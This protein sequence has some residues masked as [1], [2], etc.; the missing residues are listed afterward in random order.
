MNSVDEQRIPVPDLGPPSWSRRY[1][2]NLERL[3]SG[4]RAEIAEVVRHLSGREQA[5]GISPGE[6]RMLAR[7]RQMLDDGSDGAAGVREPRR[8]LP[9]ND[10]FGMTLPSR[11]RG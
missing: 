3:Q 6:K 10:A 2:E 8:P 11:S 7:A 5:A 1:K 4:D 9:P